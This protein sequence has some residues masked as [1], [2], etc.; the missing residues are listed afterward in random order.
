MIDTRA[1]ILARYVDRAADVARRPLVQGDPGA[2]VREAMADAYTDGWNDGEAA[3][4]VLAGMY[5]ELL[6]EVGELRA[7]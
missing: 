4:Q 6:A 1:A 3:L 7:R 2:H 5:A